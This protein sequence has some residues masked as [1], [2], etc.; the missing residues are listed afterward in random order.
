MAF[1][2]IFKGRKKKTF[3]LESAAVAKRAASEKTSAGEEKSEAYDE[4]FMAE[5]FEGLG[6]VWHAIFGE[7]D[8]IA[9][10]LPMV[11]EQGKMLEN[12]H[13]VY[14][15]NTLVA[16]IQYSESAD[17]RAGALVVKTPDSGQTEL[18]SCFPIMQGLPNRL[19]IRK[20]HPWGNGVEGVVAAERAGDGPPV[21]FFAPFY[22]RE[23]ASFTPGAERTIRLA[24]LALSCE[25]AELQEFAVDKG[26]F[27][28][29][30]RKRF[31]EENPDKTEKDFSA[32]VVSMRGSRLLFPRTYACEWEY[33]C[34]ILAVEQIRFFERLIYKLRVVFVGMDE[35]ELSGY[36][37][38][39]EYMLKGSVP[40]VGDD[41]QGILWMT[42][43]LKSE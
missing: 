23:F 38:V 3:P 21:T 34:P 20:S 37:Y 19:K 29:I 32:P 13:V 36:L 16:L 35:E 25:K 4:E 11:L 24:A 42:G 39:P 5:H 40:Q 9:P 12:C 10:R 27:Y 17:M 41:I 2:N 30:Q 18:W 22:F 6:N 31:L 15:D 43:S 26:A 8:S 33:R 14:E 28:E 1:W 7:N